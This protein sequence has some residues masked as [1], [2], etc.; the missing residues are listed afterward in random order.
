[1]VDLELGRTHLFSDRTDE[2]FEISQVQI[3]SAFFAVLLA[4]IQ[5]GLREFV[6]RRDLSREEGL[7]RHQSVELF[8]GGVEIFTK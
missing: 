6:G 7:V 2:R 3:V 5:I 8:A 4:P 1:M